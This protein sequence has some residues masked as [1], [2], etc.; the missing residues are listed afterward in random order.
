MCVKIAI[1]PADR[2]VFEVGGV[3]WDPSVG[4]TG[5]VGPVVGA[6]GLPSPL[7]PA[8]ALLK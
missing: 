6:L 1:L 2:G 4:K 3:L 5:L 8:A 7:D